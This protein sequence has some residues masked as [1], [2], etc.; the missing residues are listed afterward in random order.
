MTLWF[1]GNFPQSLLN[2]YSR[3]FIRN[4]KTS[5]VTRLDTRVAESLVAW[6]DAVFDEID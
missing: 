4:G 5:P 3:Q 1:P 2:L 6:H